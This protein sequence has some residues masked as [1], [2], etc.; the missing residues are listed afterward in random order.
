VYE[1]EL[2]GCTRDVP[3]LC[4]VPTPWLMET[5]VVDPVTFQRNVELWPR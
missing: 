4:T 2:S 5:L 1:V 3:V